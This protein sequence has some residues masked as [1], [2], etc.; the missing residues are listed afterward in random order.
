MPSIRKSSLEPLFLDEGA[1]QINFAYSPQCDKGESKIVFWIDDAA[2]YIHPETVSQ[3]LVGFFSGI[4]TF[5]GIT[6]I[7]R[8][9]LGLA[10][11][12]FGHAKNGQLL[13][14]RSWVCLVRHNVLPADISSLPSGTLFSL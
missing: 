9:P 6:Y 3:E 5:K 1:C 2:N 11:L 10:K 14:S 4:F 13:I 12:Y 7:Y 8:D